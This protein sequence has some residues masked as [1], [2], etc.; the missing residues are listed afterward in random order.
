[1]GKK[2]IPGLSILSQMRKKCYSA[3]VWHLPVTTEIARW[4]GVELYNYPKFIAGINFTRT[5]D[6]IICDLSEKGEHILTLKGPLLKTAP[7]PVARYKT[8]PVRQG[9]PL[10]G[11]V[12]V[13]HLDYVEKRNPKGVELTLGSGH[14]ICKELAGVDLGE[15]AVLYQYSADNEAVLFG[16][17][18]LIDD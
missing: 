15:K 8:Y 3:F 2:G 10:C 13:S 4:G 1:M 14:T 7:G 6:S 9:V 18:N 17:R 16:P 5:T 12:Y 11:N